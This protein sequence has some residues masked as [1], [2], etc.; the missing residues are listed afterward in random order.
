[1]ASTANKKNPTTWLGLQKQSKEE[2]DLEALELDN[3]KALNRT[4]NDIHNAKTVVSEKKK[5]LSNAK[6]STSF[7]AVTVLNAERELALATK[8][9]ADLTRIK[10][11]MF[12]AE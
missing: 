2:I 10:D 6:R 3:E 5:A 1:M 12:S 4:N 8:D 11:E 9:V 7:S